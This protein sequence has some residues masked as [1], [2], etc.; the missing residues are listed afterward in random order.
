MSLA[1]EA[2][3]ASSPPDD[4]ARAALRRCAYFLLAAL[5]LGAMTG[6]LLSLNSV[7]QIQL[8]GFLKQEGYEDWQRERPFLSANDRSR[9]CN[10][11][12]L[13]EHGTY[14][15][16][17][18]VLQPNWGTIDMVKHKNRRGEARL[19]SSKPP[20]LATLVAGVYWPIYH[21]TRFNLEKNPHGV[22]R[23]ILLIVN[24]LPLGVY[25]VYV[26][27]LAERFGRTDF[28]R[29]LMMAAAALGTYLTTY[30]VAL[31]NHLPAAVSAAIATWYGVR[32]WCDS[33][34]SL[35]HF[36][37][38]GTF[39]AFAAANELPALSF[40][41][42]LSAALLWKAPR[43]TLLAYTPPALVVA[44][45]FFGT[46]YLAHD[47]LYP[48]YFYRSKTNQADNWY[49][50]DYIDANGKKQYSY[51][52]PENKV[53]V[54]KGEPSPAVYAFHI[55][56]GH[57]GIFSLTPI[58]I[59]SLIGAMMM[60]L[61]NDRA[62]RH[63]ALFVGL[64]SIVC[65]GYYLARP[66]EDRNYGGVAAGFRWVIWFA[67]LWL[68]LLLP[69]ADFLARRTWLRVLG[70][71][72]LAVSVLSVSYHTWNPW[73]HPWLWDYTRDVNETQP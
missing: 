3:S 62:A 22:G 71:A 12:S 43:Q 49:E 48:P 59:L 5:S 37:L 44:A 72:L 42:A 53:G 16:D 63:V 26:A 67:P 54:D 27:K 36:G 1:P 14:E 25:F 55:L 19:Y 39:A 32:I 4:P 13:V 20:L 61:G 58:W 17:K 45:A 35:V 28:S 52:Y 29:L 8:Q 66:L 38:A 47:T 60:L 46:N 41:A 50:Y 57:H 7:D 24:I 65:I 68:V 18:I 69:A 56:V 10:V 6:R 51:W 73:T 31:N 64:I 23:T 9:W 40:F 2:P 21:F 15:I 34:R 11:R 70:A 33:S 30:A